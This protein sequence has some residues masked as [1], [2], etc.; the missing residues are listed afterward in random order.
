MLDFPGMAVVSEVRC[1]LNRKSAG[2][3]K[4]LPPAR[5]T[6]RR[7]PTEISRARVASQQCL[8]PLLPATAVYQNAV[9]PLN[10]SD[11]TAMPQKSN[12][13]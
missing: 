11:T 9:C 13:L 2:G 8:L 6:L 3:K 1:V 12:T 7:T 5:D 4:I 10:N